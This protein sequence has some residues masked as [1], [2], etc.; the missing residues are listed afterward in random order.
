MT[1]PKH[2]AGAPPKLTAQVDSHDIQVQSLPGDSSRITSTPVKKPRQLLLWLAVA[3]ITGTVGA[4]GL[5]AQ[6]RI[7]LLEQQLIATQDS[8]AAISGDAA[9]DIES[10]LTQLSHT[11]DAAKSE[12]LILQKDISKL[13]R[14]HSNYES[15]L[16][17]Q[18]SSIALLTQ[19]Q[20]QLTQR[21]EHYVTAAQE[22]LVTLDS[23][24]QKLST[25][26]TQSL[27]QLTELHFQLDQQLDINQAQSQ[28]FAAL[29]VVMDATNQHISQIEEQLNLHQKSLADVPALRQE[30]A[31]LKSQQAE[32]KQEFQAYRAQVTRSINSLNQAK[33]P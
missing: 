14:Q 33:Q 16:S 1:A 30:F 21:L 28:Q 31:A 7:Q 6:Q 15:K 32:F 25:Q 20:E 29:E 3:G 18:L 9:Q 13:Q 24:Q 11:Q 10:I 8:F 26:L 19:Q 4:M 12:A 27:S 2:S 5:W 17:Q 23:A 22:G